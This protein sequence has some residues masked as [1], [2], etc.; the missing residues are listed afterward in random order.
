[1]NSPRQPRKTALTSLTNLLQSVPTRVKFSQLRL[2]PNAKVP[3][4][5]VQ[6]P[7]AEKAEVYP[8]L[9]DRYMLGRSSQSC[10]IVIRNPLVSQIH[11]SI[12][13]DRSDR[14]LLGLLPR[15]RFK[16]RDENSTNGLFRGKRRI[17]STTV[18]HNDL[19]TLGPPELADA[20]RIQF[21][22]EPSL[23]IRVARVVL[24]GLSGITLAS[25]LAI[26]ASW[27]QFS[28]NPLPNSVQGP[29]IVYARDGETPL[30]PLPPNKSHIEHK[31][32]SEYSRYLPKAVMASEDSRFNW[33]IGVDPIGTGRA[34]F[35]NLKGGGI[36]EGGSTLTQQLA[37]NLLRNYVGTEDS[38]ARKLKEAAVAL[39]LEMTYSKDELILIYLNR[40]YLGFGNYG[41]EDAAQFYFG[42]PA[43]ELDLN[44]AATLAGILPAPNAFN[45]VRDNKSALEYRNRVLDRMAS[46]GYVSSE[47]ASRARRSPIELSPKARET[48]AGG[49]APYYYAQ[50]LEDLRQLMGDSVAQEGNFIVETGLDPRMQSKA[51]ET[52]KNAVAT[53][54]AQIGYSQGAIAS[55]DFRTGEIMALVGGTDYDT[56]EFNRATQ[57][58]RQPGSTF[59][60]FAYSAAL[61]KGAAPGATYSC[62]SLYWDGQEYA[63]CGGGSVDMASAIARSENTVALRVA[64][65]V[66]LNQVAQTA[67][68]MGITSDLQVVPGMV[69]GQSEASVLEMTAAFGVLGNGGVKMPVRTIRKIWDS[70]DCENRQDLSTCR[71]VY[72]AETQSGA[73]VLRPETA[74]AM[75]SMLQGVVQAGTGRNAAIGLGEAGKTGTTNDG[76]DLW[77][78]GYVP[79]REVVTGVWLGNDDNR[80]T[81]GSSANAAKVWGTYMGS[82]LK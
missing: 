61:E 47:E 7:D 3:E 65:E 40:V 64:K 71:Q 49:L 76:V 48:L 78:I 81:S 19:L 16:I 29:I 25:L 42:K 59:K 77:F 51:E 80:S 20:I 11:L 37:R 9:G 68:K 45:P 46:L 35:A 52:L 75:T 79:S 54:G 6:L 63:G 13:R 34:V 26:A 53:D 72:S 30:S 12:T 82:A 70:G 66:G 60:I 15:T 41:F 18:Y 10:D 56:S 28:I 2:K 36:R 32:L 67:K 62:A 17:R 8:L 33:H 44:E 55:I 74:A 23:L 43:K 58:Q 27:T 73:A 50:V 24:F 21:K 5:W 14:W 1:M 31:S 38:A 57:A 4:I 69:L 22:E 39:K